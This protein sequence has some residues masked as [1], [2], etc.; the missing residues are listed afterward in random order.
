ML[1]KTRQERS[2]A[3]VRLIE[4][5]ALQIRLWLFQR[6]SSESV[7]SLKFQLRP[8]PYLYLSSGSSSIVG[9][10]N[11]IPD[12]A[13]LA[14]GVGQRVR[15]KITADSSWRT[16]IRVRLCTHQPPERTDRIGSG[17]NSR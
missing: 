12:G 13:A 16:T 14:I 1:R 17:P 8:E 10:M 6:L 2:R 4:R 15:R 11:N 5:S 7:L 9:R 3:D